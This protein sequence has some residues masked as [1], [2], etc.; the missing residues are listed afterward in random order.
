[1]PVVIEIVARIGD[2]IID[3]TYLSPGATYRLGTA[4]L[5]TPTSASF[6]S[7][8]QMAG[9]V[10]VTMTRGFRVE[11]P[12]PRKR[13]DARPWIFTFASLAVHLA[14]VIVAM[15]F[16]TL[17][18]LVA[19][20][21]LPRYRFAHIADEPEPERA[22]EPDAAKVESPAAATATVQARRRAE[23][24]DRAAERPRGWAKS[25]EVYG[26]G[27][28]EAAQRLAKSME[29]VKPD[30]L[31]GLG[32]VYDPHGV[33]EQGFGGHRWD[34]DNDPAYATIKTPD[35]L[36][37]SELAASAELYGMTPAEKAKR[38]IEI[39]TALA[40]K[41]AVRGDCVPSHRIA[42]WLP[43]VDR[44]LYKSIYLADPDIAYCLT[45]PVPPA[46]IKAEPY[47]GRHPIE[48]S[49]TPPAT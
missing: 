45:Q 21:E 10:S 26:M 29:F 28:G 35:K 40:K 8:T 47:R 22:R 1:M 13:P 25:T 15:R 44:N 27:F 41:S 2:S 49:T 17:E 48:E 16:E 33:E 37:L 38:R 43:R 18:R 6:T 42:K 11:T 19:R 31:D 4:E 9:L 12:V 46:F 30:M 39:Q 5:A 3:V 7:T 24:D 36:D 14:I 34:I 20:S 23:R 32:P